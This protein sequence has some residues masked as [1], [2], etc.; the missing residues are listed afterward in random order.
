MTFIFLISELTK[1]QN[2]A[3]YFDELPPDVLPQLM[4]ARELLLG[5]DPQVKEELKYNIP[6]YT[7]QG[8]WFAYLCVQKNTPVLGFTFG[9]R[10]TSHQGLFTA[11][12]RKYIRHLRLLQMN[13]DIAEV[14]VA[15]SAE[16]IE[17][18]K[19]KYK[20]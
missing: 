12:D 20:T 2:T 16:S 13:D 3:E 1:Y 11:L 4:A 7:F 15:L 9:H 6:F 8:R 10:L 18:L 19:N 14:I 17:Y 5:A